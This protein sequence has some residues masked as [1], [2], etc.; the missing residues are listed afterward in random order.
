[1]VFALHTEKKAKL[2]SDYKST[3]DTPW[4]ALTGE[5]W[6][7]FSKFFGEQIPQENASTLH[8][9]SLR[10]LVYNMNKYSTCARRLKFESCHMQTLAPVAAP[11]IVVL[12]T[13]GA[14]SDD[15]ACSM[16]TPRALD[17]GEL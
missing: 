10:E 4:L 9:D 11:E 13:H 8:N 16:T 17:E 15:K 1:M 7:A 12:T 6:G 2:W 5:P 14:A 3:I